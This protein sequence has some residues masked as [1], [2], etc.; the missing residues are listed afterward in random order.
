MLMFDSKKGIA[1]YFEEYISEN[2]CVVSNYISGDYY[3]AHK[4]DLVEFECKDALSEKVD[5]LS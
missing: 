3:I 2:F 4:D 1:V 5:K